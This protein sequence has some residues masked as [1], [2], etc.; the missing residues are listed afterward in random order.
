M[1]APMKTA[2]SAGPTPPSPESM[3]LFDPVADKPLGVPRSWRKSPSPSARTARRA[4]KS[5]STS[6]PSGTTRPSGTPGSDSATAPKRTTT[7]SRPTKPPISATRRSAAPADTPT[8]SSSRVPRPPSVTCGVS[9]ATS[10]PKRS[11]LSTSPPF[12]HADESTS[13][14]TRSSTPS[15]LET[16]HGINEHRHADDCAYSLQRR[17]CWVAPQSD[18]SAPTCRTAIWPPGTLRPQEAW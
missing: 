15:P 16:E 7:G 13:T 11:T 9:S 5:S 12:A 3:R 8:N 14:A 18:V 1:A 17:V 10:R 4:S 6:R 2:T